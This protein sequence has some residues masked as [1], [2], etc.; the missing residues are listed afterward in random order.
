[1]RD[2]MSGLQYRWVGLFIFIITLFFFNNSHAQT[3]LV[4]GSDPV[5]IVLLPAKD[6]YFVDLSAFPDIKLSFLLRRG[7]QFVS[8]ELTDLTLELYEDGHQIVLGSS[9]IPEKQP[10]TFIIIFL[11]LLEFVVSA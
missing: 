8:E 9:L 11:I 4:Y 2:T 1:M 10:I 6:G 7:S 5:E 3:I